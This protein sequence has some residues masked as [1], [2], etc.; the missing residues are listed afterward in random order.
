MRGGRREGKIEV[1]RA[2]GGNS[3][4]SVCVRERKTERVFLSYD[5][6]YMNCLNMNYS[7]ILSCLYIIYY[8]PLAL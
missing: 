4:G 6:Q 2:G 8:K 3:E 7:D 5:F 1:E